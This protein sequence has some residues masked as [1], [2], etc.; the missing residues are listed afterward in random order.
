MFDHAWLEGFGGF[1]EE[2]VA[3]VVSCEPLAA[4]AVVWAS[5]GEREPEES[6]DVVFG[7]VGFREEEE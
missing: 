3:V 6:D 1:V 7:D 2:G 4:V 5:C